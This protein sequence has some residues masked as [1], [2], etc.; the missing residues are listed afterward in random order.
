MKRYIKS[1]YYD[2]Y[3]NI[4]SMLKSAQT[5]EDMEEIDNIIQ[6]SIYAKD[7]RKGIDDNDNYLSLQ[8]SWNRRLQEL[9]L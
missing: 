9:G 7:A 4:I 2:E 6:N 8:L 3:H 5:Y 1:N